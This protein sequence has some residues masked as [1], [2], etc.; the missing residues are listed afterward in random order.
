[1]WDSDSTYTQSPGRIQKT[2]AP[3]LDSNTPMLQIILKVDPFFGSSQGSGKGSSRCGVQKRG[4][5]RRAIEG[6]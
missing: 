1:M 2:E 5:Y 6:L 3:I 4:V